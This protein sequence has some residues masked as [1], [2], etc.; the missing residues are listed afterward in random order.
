VSRLRKET[1]RRGVLVSFIEG[2]NLNR[3]LSIVPITAE[4]V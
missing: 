4:T 1:L 3:D 2:I